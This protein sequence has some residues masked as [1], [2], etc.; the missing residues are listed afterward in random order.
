M[1]RAG[2]AL[3]H[4]TIAEAGGL[5]AARKLSPVELTKALLQRVE[6]LNPALDAYLH[7]CGKSALAAARAA[8]KTVA[9]RAQGPLTGIPLAYKDIYETRGVPTTA[10]SRL[11]QDNVPREDAET[12]R[13]LHDA[14]AVMLG[15]LA[16]HEFAIGG[17]AFDLPWPPAR[18]PWDRDRFTG[19]SSSGSGAAL[20]AG[21]AL[22]SLGSDTGGSIRLPAAYCGVAG[23]KPT[24]GLVSRRGVIPL[25]P[26]L[27]TAGPLAWTAEDCAILLDAIAGHDPLDSA[28]VPVPSGG[29][30]KGLTQPV[31]GLRVGLLRHFHERD[32]PAT[33]EVRQMVLAAAKTLESLGCVVEEAT[34]PPVQEYDAVARPIICAEAYAL[35][36]QWLRTRLEDYSRVFRLRVMG[37]ALVRA[38]DYIA[39][40]RTR[41]DLIRATEAAFQR[42]DILI[43]A[44]APQAAPRLADQKPDEGLTRPLLTIPANVAAIPALSVCGGFSAGG[45]PLGLQIM[46]PAW[47]DAL[48]LRVGHQFE[49]A[50]GTRARRPPL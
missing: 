5:I 14:G 45:L 3:H 50:A 41:G 10:H 8:E 27:D 17:P 35:H 32:V 16:T 7:V 38:A 46:G 30:T 24:A 11:L 20:A 29:Y 47:S 42:F 6:Q 39:A 4:L 9:A 19:G 34:L 40:Q 1:S 2:A 21:L 18:N 36:E 25:S 43:S 44:T 33:A 31:K 37:G 28:S 13:R 48:V 22:G 49:E 23:L 12:V 26:S 15:K